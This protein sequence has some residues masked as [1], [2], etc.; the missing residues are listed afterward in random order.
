VDV[1][2]LAVAS[3]RQNLAI[4]EILSARVIA[5]DGLEAVKGERY[6]LIASNP[7]F[8]AGKGVDYQATHEFIRRS[9]E[10]LLPGGR[11]VLV[12]NQFIPYERVMQEAFK[13]VKK[14]VGDGKYEVWEGK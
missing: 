7:P 13:K 11:L 8:H 6:H 5:G 3:T 1:N 10:A 9:R 14:L 2:F 12:A 4:L